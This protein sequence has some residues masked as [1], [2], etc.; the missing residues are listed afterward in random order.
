MTAPFQIGDRV[1]I[2]NPDHADHNAA[3][4]IVD[5]DQTYES[6]PIDVLIDGDWTKDGD[7][8]TPNWFEPSELV[9]VERPS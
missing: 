1:R 7:H 9:L 3:G 4:L 6:W 5:I 2:N 8:R